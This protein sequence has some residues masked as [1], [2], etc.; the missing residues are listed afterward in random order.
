MK[1]FLT[2]LILTYGSS[3]FSQ[4]TFSDSSNTTKAQFET[5]KKKIESIRNDIMNGKIDFASAAIKYSQ[6]PGSAPQG[7]LYKNAPKGTF[8][9]DFEAVALSIEVNKISEVFETRWGYHVLIVVA[10]RGDEID[11]RHILIMPQSDKKPNTSN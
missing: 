4:P 8:D 5:A 3:L 2:I 9:P 11:V 7:G 10:R 1:K 6:D